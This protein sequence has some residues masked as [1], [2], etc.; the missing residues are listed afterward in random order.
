MK[1][2]GR[3]RNFETTEIKEIID[4]YVLYTQATV[5]LNASRIA[6]YAQNKKLH[7]H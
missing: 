2:N 3:P 1:K 7:L 4:E 6:E 5:I